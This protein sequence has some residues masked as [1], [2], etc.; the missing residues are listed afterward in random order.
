MSDGKVGERK[1]GERWNRMEVEK[2][3]RKFAKFH[4]LRFRCPKCHYAI[5]DRY[6]DFWGEQD[7]IGRLTLFANVNCS[8]CREEFVVKL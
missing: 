8:R 3:D 6:P 1:E 4:C 7:F 2:K 5:N